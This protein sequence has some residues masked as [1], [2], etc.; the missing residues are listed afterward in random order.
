M[1][2]DPC[3]ATRSAVYKLVFAQRD[4]VSH[5]VILN[6]DMFIALVNCLVLSGIDCPLAVSE[7]LHRVWL[8]EAGQVC[9]KSR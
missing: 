3:R 4:I 7:Y 8:F 5:I 6:V 1:T 9:Y 2:Q